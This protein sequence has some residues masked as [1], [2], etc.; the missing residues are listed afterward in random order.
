M[1]MTLMRSMGLGVTR[2]NTATQFVLTLLL[3]IT[4]GTTTTTIAPTNTAM[5]KFAQSLLRIT[6]TTTVKNLSL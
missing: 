4:M 3:V 6:T 1:T 5:G 2:P